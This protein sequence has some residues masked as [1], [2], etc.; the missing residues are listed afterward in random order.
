LAEAALELARL[1]VREPLWGLAAKKTMEVDAALAELDHAKAL[2]C[3]TTEKIKDE[4]GV[5]FEAAQEWLT[6]WASEILAAT[7]ESKDVAVAQSACNHVIAE[8]RTDRFCANVELEKRMSF[9]TRFVNPADGTVDELKEC[10]EYINNERS[11]KCPFWMIIM[12]QPGAKSL[13]GHLKDFSQIRGKEGAFVAAFDK[14]T[15]VFKSL[16]E[17]LHSEGMD[18]AQLLS[19]FKEHAQLLPAHIRALASESPREAFLKQRAE[20]IKEA[21]RTVTTLA[22]DLDAK[23]IFP[24][25]KSIALDSDFWQ[26][27][28][29]QNNSSVDVTS[30]RHY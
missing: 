23:L 17:K 8:L 26:G 19:M 6:K 1:Q 20:P 21:I 15:A 9:L 25:W 5:L 13:Q 24:T 14:F 27:M 18:H 28:D 4:L 10:V 30:S 2:D 7:M 22:L 3:I 12:E 16:A 29:K 11:K